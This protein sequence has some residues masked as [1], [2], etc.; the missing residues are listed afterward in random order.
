MRSAPQPSGKGLLSGLGAQSSQQQGQ[1]QKEISSAKQ[2]CS[3]A[4][5]IASING[6]PWGPSLSWSSQGQIAV[7]T[8]SH[9]KLYSPTNCTATFSAQSIQQTYETIW[10]PDGKKVLTVDA[11]DNT[12][13]IFDNHG[14]SLAH[15][16][17]PQLGTSGVGSLVWSS[18]SNKIIFS[19]RNAANQESVKSI[20]S[21]NNY[22]VTTVLTL[23]A[24]SAGYLYSPDGKLLLV[25]HADMVA[26]TKVLQLWDVT[27]GKQI[28]SFAPSSFFGMAFS[29]DGSLVAGSVDVTGGNSQIQIYSTANGKLVSSFVSSSKFIASLAWSPDGKYLAASE[30]SINLYDVNAQKTI[31]TFGQVDTQHAITAL[32]WS[33]NS[34]S[35][36]SSA[37]TVQE[38]AIPDDTVTVWAL[39]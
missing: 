35:L 21:S 37:G 17:F 24:D 13:Y 11:G 19:A 1:Q 23:P 15:L 31:A 25:T 9:F 30:T 33:P 34:K 20:D 39:S 4:S 28:S 2:V 5:E 36:V 27:T 12:L 8:Y 22:K 7:A 29:P 26:H 38:G 10:S 3:F 16:S 14:S 32:A 6:A 18:D